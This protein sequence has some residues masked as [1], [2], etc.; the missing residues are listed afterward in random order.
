VHFVLSTLEGVA[1]ERG[2]IRIDSEPVADVDYEQLFPRLA[3]VR[4]GAEQPEGDIYNVIGDDSGRAGWKKLLNA[5][6]FSDGPLKNWPEETLKHFPKGTEL[7]DVID[8]LRQKHTPIEHLFGTGL[9]FQLMRIESDMLI[10][11]ILHLFKKGITA[12]PLHDA[13]LVA[14][15]CAPTAKEVMQAEFSH[16]TGSSCAIV[17]IKVIPI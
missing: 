11:V 9:G 14:K 3:Y 4:A 17:S 5:M 16:R 2:R 15:S 10:S 12:L 13:A 8:A 1:A 6:L 7:R